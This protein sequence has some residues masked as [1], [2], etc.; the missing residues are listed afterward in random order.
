[1]TTILILFILGLLV[2]Q[3]WINHKVSKLL[4]FYEMKSN[5]YQGKYNECRK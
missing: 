2:G 3:I 4:K 1:M 5:F